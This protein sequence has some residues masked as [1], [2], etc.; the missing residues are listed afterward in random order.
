MLTRL[1]LVITSQYIQIHMNHYVVH[2]KLIYVNYT[3][4]KRNKYLSGLNGSPPSCQTSIVFGRSEWSERLSD[5]LS[6]SSLPTP[7]L[8]VRRFHEHLS[9]W[10]KHLGRVP[11]PPHRLLQ[12]PLRFF[13]F[14]NTKGHR[15]GVH[16]SIRD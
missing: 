2:M 3:S 8:K 11:C 15:S 1:D 7:G 6:P 16:S 13:Y 10:E 9:G 4:I 5:V 14:Q 12:L